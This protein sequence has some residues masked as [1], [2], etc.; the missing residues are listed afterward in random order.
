MNIQNII[1]YI[2]AFLSM[3]SLI[4]VIIALIKFRSLGIN[5]EKTFNERD[6]FYYQRFNIHPRLTRIIREIEIEMDIRLTRGSREMIAIPLIE[7]R[8]YDE[9]INWGEV[10][11]SV[12]DLVLTMKEYQLQYKSQRKFD[13]FS[14]IFSLH[15]RFCNIPPFCKPTEN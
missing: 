8:E 4:G 15:K 9:D 10:K 12:K 3:T 1:I 6:I 13:S 14:L 7:L 5:F 2:L 11:K